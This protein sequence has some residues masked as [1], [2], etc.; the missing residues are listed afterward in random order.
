MSFCL[1]YIFSFRL[2]KKFLRTYILQCEL[3]VLTETCEICAANDLARLFLGFEL[4]K[5]CAKS[6]LFGDMLYPHWPW[7]W[8]CFSLASGESQVLL[9]P[10]PLLLLR[11]LLLLL[12]PLLLLLLVV[13]VVVVVVCIESNGSS[14]DLYF[15]PD[16]KFTFTNAAFHFSVPKNY[17]NMQ[18]CLGPILFGDIVAIPAPN[19]KWNLLKDG[20]WN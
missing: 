3:S 17:M 14:K 11:Y 8:T 1:I 12:L 10:P 20:L 4:R 13:V 19:T 6:N 15:F 18:I 9:P 7:R 16:I 2:Y 5:W